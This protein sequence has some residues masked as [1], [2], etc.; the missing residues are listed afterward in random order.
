MLSDS[1]KRF[2]S[3]TKFQTEVIYF[4][5][6]AYKEYCRLRASGE[7]KEFK[8]VREVRAGDDIVSDRILKIKSSQLETNGQD[9]GWACGYHSSLNRSRVIDKSIEWN[10]H[11]DPQI[12]YQ[13][14]TKYW[15][16]DYSVTAEQVIALTYD[17]R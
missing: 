8:R 12:R 6:F 2:H 16:I 10:E 13:H 1:I 14:F 3:I 5:D 11:P 9:N 7:F 4:L 15:S 17:L